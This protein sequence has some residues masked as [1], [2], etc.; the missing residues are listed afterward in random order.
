MDVANRALPTDF[1]RQKSTQAPI[2]WIAKNCHASS[3]REQYINELMKY[4][5]IDSYGDCLNTKPFPLDTSREQLMAKYKFYLAIEN[6]NCE[7]YVTEKLVDTLLYSAVPIIDGPASYSGY[8]PNQRSAIRM[9]A[10][11]DPREL[12]NYI[13]FLD[14]NDDAYLSYLQYRLDALSKSPMERLDPLF[15]SLWG[16]Q[17]AHNYRVS[18]CSICRHMATSWI[19]RH[20]K[21]NSNLA[22]ILEQE[23]QRKERFIVDTTCMP[24]GKWNYAAAGPPYQSYSWTPTPKDEFAYEV[25]GLTPPQLPLP[26]Q[27]TTTATPLET[28]TPT[29][30]TSQKYHQEKTVQPTNLSLENDDLFFQDRVGMFALASISVT[31]LIFVLWLAYRHTKCTKSYGNKTPLVPL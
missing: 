19:S 18:W 7:D 6:A 29:T 31:V 5:N 23:P 15:I 22:T 11:P 10:Y 20:N 1:M 12:A 9:D 27:P 14:E 13:R 3:G 17:T 21:N 30:S 16:D 2:L 26:L 25:L 28:T 4:I 24:K 8:L